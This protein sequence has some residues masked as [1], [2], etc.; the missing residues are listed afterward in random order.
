VRLSDNLDCPDACFVEDT[1][2]VLDELAIITSMGAL[3]RRKE[4]GAIENVLSGHR[5]LARVK[6]PA[7]IEGGD[8]LRVGKRIFVGL[9]SRTNLEGV[10]AITQI[11]G[12]LG[13]EVIPVVVKNSL[14][15]KTGCTAIDDETVLMNPNWI[16]RSAFD[17]F[18][19]IHTPEEEPW[20]ASTL[21]LAGIVCMD[22]LQTRTRELLEKRNVKVETLDISEFRKAEAGLSCLSLIFDNAS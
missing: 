3:S 8:V 19:I 17:D 2:I 6:L 14:H 21:R 5:K 11:L 13:Y 20:A 10:Q 22:P 16:D 12:P 4:T 1:A 18:D 9:S 7:T 15:L